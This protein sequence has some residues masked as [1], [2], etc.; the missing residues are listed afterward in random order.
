MARPTCETSSESISKQESEAL[1]HFISTSCRSPV[2]IGNKLAH[3]THLWS[4]KKI[5]FARSAKNVRV[6]QS[7]QLIIHVVD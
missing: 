6:I 2:G 3:Q 7:V 4:K 1:F 5:L